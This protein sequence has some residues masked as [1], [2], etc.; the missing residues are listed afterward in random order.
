[1]SRTYIW[2]DRSRPSPDVRER[3]REALRARVVRQQYRELEDRIRR[4]ALGGRAD[5]K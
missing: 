1:M 3:A 4:F 2:T 5:W